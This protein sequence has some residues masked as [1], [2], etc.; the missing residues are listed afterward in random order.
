MKSYNFLSPTSALAKAA[1]ASKAPKPLSRTPI[2]T[3][4]QQNGLERD[5][6]VTS[7]PTPASLAATGDVGPQENGEDKRLPTK[8]VGRRENG[9]SPPGSTK[10]ARQ[11]TGL[12][13]PLPSSPPLPFPA[14]A[15]FPYG[16]SRHHWKLGAATPS[17]SVAPVIDE[18]ESEFERPSQSCRAGSPMR[19]PLYPGKD[20]GSCMAR[21]A[22]ISS[23]QLAHR[24]HNAVLSQ[25]SRGPFL[26]LHIV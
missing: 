16:Q 1:T 3:K 19:H 11:D 13:A 2:S 9:G 6:V 23:A 20:G 14:T 26:T 8:A 12:T 7:S 18:T 22:S 25:P 15:G 4:V 21:M 24:T 10:G 17:S 5:S